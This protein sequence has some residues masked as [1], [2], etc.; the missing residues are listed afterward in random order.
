MGRGRGV[1]NEG[2][3]GVLLGRG[4]RILRAGGGV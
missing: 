1:R 3:D 4:L 2:D